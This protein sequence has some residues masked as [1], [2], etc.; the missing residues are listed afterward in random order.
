LGFDWV[1]RKDG[2]RDSIPGI[3]YRLVGMFIDLAGEGRLLVWKK[4]VQ[5][6]HEAI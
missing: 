3:L 1:V 6:S 5:V 4:V 2:F